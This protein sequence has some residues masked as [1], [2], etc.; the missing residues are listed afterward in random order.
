LPANDFDLLKQFYPNLNFRELESGFSVEEVGANFPYSSV[1]D[2][3]SAASK[4]SLSVPGYSAA[5][6]TSL[7]ATDARQKLA[8][9]KE[10]SL[11]KIDSIFEDALAFAKN[12]FPDE[13]AKTH[14]QKLRGKLADFPQSGGEWAT[15]RANLEKEVDEMARLASKK[16]E[17]HAHHG[18]EEGEEGDHH[19]HEKTLSP[20]Q[21][22]EAKYGRNLDELQER[23]SKFKSDPK[24]FLESSI[25]EKYGKNGLD[26][27]K[28][29][30]EFSERL[31]VITEADK[32]AAEAEFTNFLKKA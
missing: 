5:S 30:Q 18:E 32:E 16:E 10:A 6:V 7:E 31:S 4:K 28:K 2:L 8:V 26:V 11:K 23:F 21:E 20:A 1:K 25:I 3:L 29:S 22:F 24:G 9:L 13:E 27:W 17:H 19:A 14:Y 12:P 15:Y